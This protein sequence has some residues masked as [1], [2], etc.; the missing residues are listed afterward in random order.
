MVSL[1]Q[2]LIKSACYVII[3]VNSNVGGVGN[4]YIITEKYQETITVHI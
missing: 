3:P 2:Y 4:P 1:C